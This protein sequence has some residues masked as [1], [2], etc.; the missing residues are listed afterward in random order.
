[1][2]K[3][4][5]KSGRDELSLSTTSGMRYKSES[6]KKELRNDR[7]EWQRVTAAS[8]RGM[9]ERSTFFKANPS[10]ELPFF[11]VKGM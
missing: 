5:S 1:M 4:R 11:D 10:R 2:K 7:L 3:L 6:I 8:V 9:V